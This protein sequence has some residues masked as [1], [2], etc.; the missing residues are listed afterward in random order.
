[1]LS[2]DHGIFRR[3]DLIYG[4]TIGS[5]LF[6]GE[7]YDGHPLI[8]DAAC[9]RLAQE[10]EISVVRWMPRQPFEDM[11]GNLSDEA[12]N[13]VIDGIR[14]V[15]ALPLIALPPGVYTQCTPTADLAWLTAIVTRAGD[16]VLL[17]ELG[18]E[19]DYYC[20]WDAEQY[21]R[22]WI[23]VVP[24]LKRHARALGFE[25]Y[26]GGPAWSLPYMPAMQTFLRGVKAEYDRTGDADL[27]PSFVSFHTFASHSRA[28]TDEMILGRVPGY[29]DFASVLREEIWL[30]FGF[31]LPVADTEWNFT[32]DVGDTRDRDEAFMR[33]FTQGMLDEF[34][35]H[36]VWLANQFAFAS[37]AGGGVLDMVEISCTP[38]PMYQAF[39]EISSSDGRSGPPRSKVYLP[40]VRR[41]TQP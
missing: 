41:S 9:Q 6:Q 3:T 1:V 22:E 13:N 15:G 25:I 23:R 37:D 14:S 36:G 11:G 10:A 20:G 38:K 33:A 2:L 40:I 27:I 12:F 34:R 35:E 5:W 4:S 32:T 26:I 24:Q 8:Q 30:I 21:T 19:P 31:E 18:N 7:R 39:K 29:G 17:Y 16:R 28:D